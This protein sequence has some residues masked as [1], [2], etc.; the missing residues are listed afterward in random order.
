MKLEMTL[1]DRPGFLH[2]IPVFDLIMSVTMLLLLG[3]MFLSQGGVS[4]K[5]PESRFQMERY[6]D[7]IVVTIG[8]R[9]GQDQKLYLG[10]QVVSLDELEKHF[11]ERSRDENA[12]GSLVLLKS[13]I[14]SSVGMERK[15]SEMVLRSGLKLALVG[16]PTR[17]LDDVRT[18]SLEEDDQE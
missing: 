6:Q 8:K 12:T 13:D 5:L 15:I 10:R 4:V 3:P 11:D 7:S 2:A 14:G 16:K 1:T 17:L 9:V 18:P